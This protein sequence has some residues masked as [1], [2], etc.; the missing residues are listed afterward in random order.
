[1]GRRRLPGGTWLSKI[2]TLLGKTGTLLAKMVKVLKVGKVALGAASVVSYAILFTWQ[3]AVVLVAMLIAHEYGHLLLMK[4]FGMK[5]KGLYLIPFVG[6]AAVAEENFPSRKA[7]AVTAIAGPLV[8]TGFALVFAGAYALTGNAYCA[9]IASMTALIN[10]FNL[11]PTTPLDGGRIMKSVAMSIGSR[12]GLAVIILGL[13]VGAVFAF[14]AQLFIFVIL[15]P[16]GILDYFAEYATVRKKKSHVGFE[17]N[18]EGDI[19]FVHRT[20]SFKQTLEAAATIKPAMSKRL[21][22]VV[23]VGYAALAV[24]LWGFTAIMAAE[25]GALNALQFLQG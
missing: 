5:T 23:F 7:E 8:G 14:E 15:I 20:P 9:A 3:F 11:L 12:I 17:Q 25:P 24:F 4:R 22:A 6:A 10:L 19:K 18:E 16:F 2:A 13:L 1:M 21:N